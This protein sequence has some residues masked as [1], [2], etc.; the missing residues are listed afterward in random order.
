MDLALPLAGWYS[1][2]NEKEDVDLCVR[3]LRSEGFSVGR[4]YQSATGLH[5]DL[6]AKSH[7]KL[8]VRLLTPAT[9]LGE[10]F[11][12]KITG[13]VESPCLAFN[14]RLSSLITNSLLGKCHKHGV[15]L[16]PI[17]PSK[18]K[19]VNPHLPVSKIHHEVR[20]IEAEKLGQLLD[21]CQPGK[22]DWRDYEDICEEVFRVLFVPPLTEP[23]V[24]AR[25]VFEIRRRDFIFPNHTTSGFWRSIVRHRYKGEYVLL[26]SKNLREP[27]S[28]EE[29]E[30]GLSY[31][32]PNGLGMFGY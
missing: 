21:R 19:F 30:Q 4:N 28:K 2:K 31:L 22:R 25:T 23:I 17:T 5:F 16:C 27:I 14:S 18:I 24:Q 20:R 29:F 1:S 7:Q 3:L 15:Q 11:W 6:S 26:E 12:K 8:A 32:G 9:S 10:Q 13:M